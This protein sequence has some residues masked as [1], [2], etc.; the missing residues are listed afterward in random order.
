VKVPGKVV[1]LRSQCSVRVS[2]NEYNP[3]D[4]S[5]SDEYISRDE[6]VNSKTIP[7]V[8]FVSPADGRKHEEELAYGG[9]HFYPGRE[10]TVFASK[11]DPHHIEL[12]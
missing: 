4:C 12:Y 7:M 9:E 5:K 2:R 10:F 3:I 11:T 6:I 8:S 1:S